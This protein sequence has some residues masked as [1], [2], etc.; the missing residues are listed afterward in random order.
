LPNYGSRTRTVRGKRGI[1]TDFEEKGRVAR[2][3]D[4]GR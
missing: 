3:R 4:E 2:A 1:L